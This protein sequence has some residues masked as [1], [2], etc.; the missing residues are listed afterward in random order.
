MLK[1]C[2]C[3]SCLSCGCWAEATCHSF[4]NPRSIEMLTSLTYFTPLTYFS[5]MSVFMTYKPLF[6]FFPHILNINI[7]GY[8]S[9]NIQ[10]WLTLIAGWC[11]G[12]LRVCTAALLP[13]HIQWQHANRERNHGSDQICRIL[14]YQSGRCAANCPHGAGGSAVLWYDPSS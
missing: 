3:Y 6:S 4:M 12:I 8:F 1:I 9:T 7:I 14:Q 2:M 13:Q 5:Q 11:D 10:I